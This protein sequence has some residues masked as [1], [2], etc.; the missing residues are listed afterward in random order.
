MKQKLLVIRFSSIGDIL[1]TAPVIR[2]LKEAGHHITF[3]VKSRFKSTALLL[4]GIDVVL[5]WEES[6]KQILH[7]GSAGFDRI[8]DLQGT[9]QSKRFTKKLGIPTDTFKKPYARRAL[10]IATKDQRYAL[11]PV[12]DRYAEAAGVALKTKEI[13][14]NIKVQTQW[15]DRIVFVIGGSKSGKRLV[16]QQW[17]E[18]ISSLPQREV[19]LLGGPDDQKTALEI[20]ST[21]PECMDATHTSVEEG[22]AVIQEAKLVISGDTGFMHAAAL[23]GVPLISLWGATHPSLGFGPWPARANQRCIITQAPSP[24]SKHGKVPFYAANPMLKLDI[25]EIQDAIAEILQD[26]TKL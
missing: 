14:F 8:I 24:Q 11:T 20:I 17:L 3:L 19:V 22:M 21:F 5:C 18:I 7:V 1:L 12:V 6:S 9:A 15:M 16:N 10:L 2:E 23:M 26:R 4:H 25:K 13:K